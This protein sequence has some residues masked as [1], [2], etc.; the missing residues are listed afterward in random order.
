MKNSITRRAAA[1]AIGLGTAAAF[2]APA[3]LADSNP[4][5]DI[6]ALARE[7]ERIETEVIPPLT[8]AFDEA[9]ERVLNA[10]PH[11]SPPRYTLAEIDEREASMLRTLKGGT[12]NIYAELTRHV[13]RKENA[14]VDDETAVANHFAPDRAEVKQY[15]EWRKARLQ[16]EKETGFVEKEQRMYRA[17]DDAEAIREKIC[18]IPAST[19]A[20]YRIKLEIVIDGKHPDTIATPE[21]IADKALVSLMRDLKAG[22]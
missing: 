2:V 20:G 6:L 7:L 17:H 16:V 18:S 19:E 5:A 4:D 1:K 10:V 22:A 13:M 15:E 9:E 14:G 21:Y 8:K 3:A 12:D 11:Q